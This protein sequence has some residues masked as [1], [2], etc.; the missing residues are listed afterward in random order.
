M[1][2]LVAG[3][4]AFRSE[5]M[6]VVFLL[7]LLCAHQD[8]RPVWAALALFLGALTKETAWLLAPLMIVALELTGCALPRPLR[9]PRASQL[10]ACLARVRSKRSLFLAEAGAFGVAS[11]LRYSYAPPWRAHQLPLNVDTALG[12][13]L[14]GLA[15]SALR[16]AW[17]FDGSICDAFPVTEVMSVTA[18]IGALVLAG[19]LLLGLRQRVGL[20]FAL[21]LLP[22]LQL[23]PIM[24]WW[25]PHYLYIPLAFAVMLIA[26]ALVRWRRAGALVGASMVLIL[27]AVSFNQGYRYQSDK[28][29][30]EPEVR[31]NPRCREGQFFLGEIARSAGDW[32]EARTRYQHALAVSPTTLAY[33]DE[34]AALQNLGAAQMALGETS[35]ARAVWSEALQRAGTDRQARYITHNLAALELEAGHPALAA[36]LLEEESQRQDA[37][38]E[39]LL[40]RARALKSLGRDGEAWPLVKR[41]SHRATGAR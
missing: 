15:K 21:S 1:G 17:P 30:W 16:L 25:S 28:K 8:N 24:R 3:A 12:T 37:L 26:R 7:G 23:I 40:I 5:A 22:S 35:Q 10:R 39:S 19:V 38:A 32:G 6:I 18:L 29:L 11:C 34:L 4:V 36:R 9:L 2:A 31:E 13:R 20:L 27:A 33:A 41:L 14:A